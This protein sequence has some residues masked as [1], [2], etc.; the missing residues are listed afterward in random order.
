NAANL[1]L[2]ASPRRLET[3]LRIDATDGSADLTGSLDD[4]DPARRKYSVDANLRNFDVAKIINRPEYESDLTL[5]T[6]ISGTGRELDELTGELTLSLLRST[7]RGREI[8]P[9]DVHITLDQ[10]SADN[11]HLTFTSSFADVHCDGRFDLDLA[12]AAIVNRTADV[13]R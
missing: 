7:Y 3:T 8:S 2:I 6:Q 11:K 9:Q 10:T 5:H 1:H 4:T 13:I 12:A